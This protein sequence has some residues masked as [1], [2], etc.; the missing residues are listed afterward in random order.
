MY[1]NCTLFYLSF[2]FSKAP[3]YSPDLRFQNRITLLIAFMFYFTN[4]KICYK[5]LEISF[6]KASLKED[7]MGERNQ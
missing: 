2:S 6:V 5:Y 1:E 3:T 7:T 4:Y